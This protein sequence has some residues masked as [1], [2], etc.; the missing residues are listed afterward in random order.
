MK[1][2]FIRGYGKMCSGI[3]TYRLQSSLKEQGKFSADEWLYCGQTGMKQEL[4][5]CQSRFG[6]RAKWLLLG[7]AAL[8]LS[9]AVLSA[10][11]AGNMETNLA[12][13]EYG[14]APTQIRLKMKAEYKG[15]SFEQE[16]GLNILPKE[17]TTQQEIQRLDLCVGLLEK[18]LLG[19]NE[20]LQKITTDLNLPT[21]HEASGVS[22]SWEST[23]RVRVGI[24]G[25]VNLFHLTKPEEITLYATLSIGE[26]QRQCAYLLHLDAS[27]SNDY[28]SGIR[29]SS[30]DL[31]QNLSRN[32]R[33]EALDLP[34]VTPEGVQ[35]EWS[36]APKSTPLLLMTMGI[37]LL[38]VLNFSKYDRLSKEIKYRKYAVEEEIPNVALQLTLLLN[39]GL[40][41]SAAFEEMNRQNIDNAHPLY[42][43][44]GSLSARSVQSNDSFIKTFYAFS[45]KAGS[46]NLLRFATMVADHETR[47]SELVDKL[48][49][50]RGQMWESRL[51]QAKAKAREADTRLCM[52]LMLLLLVII[53][54]SAAPA[55]LQIQ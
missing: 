30:A 50:E 42:R 23:D 35:L 27:A 21:F 18:E 53:V 12:R 33:G 41:V 17:L 11:T 54:I 24:D 31:I 32:S 15:A 5:S 14:E 37:F 9:A 29:R 20:S 16:V 3:R 51:Q 1:E 34:S 52:P 19:R 43:I 4:L 49:R 26:S 36:R 25:T 39:A 7:T 45:Q 6:I 55:F 46:R 48:E 28:A 47:G 44:L 8:I 2:L 40:V 10:A 13:V 38:L 22:L